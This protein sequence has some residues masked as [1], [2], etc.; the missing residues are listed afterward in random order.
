MEE[1]KQNDIPIGSLSA[2]FNETYYKVDRLMEGMGYE[3]IAFK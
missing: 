1:F 2:A 3:Q